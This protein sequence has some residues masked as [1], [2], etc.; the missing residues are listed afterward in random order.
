VPVGAL[1][2][3]RFDVS[4]SNAEGLVAAD[5]GVWA[6]IRNGLATS[7]A[8]LLWSLQL[9]VIGLLLVGPW[10]VLGWGVWKLVRRWRPARA[11]APQ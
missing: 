10:V 4:L 8:G 6:T 5:R 9:I 2:R 11:L 1:T 7:L 3:A